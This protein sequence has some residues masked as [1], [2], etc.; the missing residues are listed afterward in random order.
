MHM[1]VYLCPCLHVLYNIHVHMYT[2][3]AVLVCVFPCVY[4]CVAHNAERV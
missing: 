3:T 1:Y 4:L 2:H